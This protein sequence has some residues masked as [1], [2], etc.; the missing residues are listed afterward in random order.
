MDERGDPCRAEE[1]VGDTMVEVTQVRRDGRSGD[2]E[3][4]EER[5]KEDAVS[6]QHLVPY[7]L[8]NSADSGY[9]RRR[10]SVQQVLDRLSFLCSVRGQRYY[11][12]MSSLEISP[13]TARFFSKTRDKRHRHV[14][15]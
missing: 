6:R 14:Q 2:L 3:T 9:R 4:S 7:S 12:L 13:S 11:L 10:P 8:S 15:Y 5:F 1:K